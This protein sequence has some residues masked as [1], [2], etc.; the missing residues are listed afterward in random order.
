MVTADHLT[1]VHPEPFPHRGVAVVLLK[2]LSAAIQDNDE[3]LALS[4]AMLAQ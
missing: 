1:R 2:R 4:P 3:I